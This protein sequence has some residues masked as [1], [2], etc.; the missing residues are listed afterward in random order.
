MYV[1]GIDPP[2][3]LR[4]DEGMSLLATECTMPAGL[5]LEV[6]LARA[7]ERAEED[8]VTGLLEGVEPGELLIQNLSVVVA[9]KEV[10]ESITA[11][12]ASG[13]TKD[14][15]APTASHGER[16]ARLRREVGDQMWEPRF[17]IL[18]RQPMWLV[19]QVQVPKT[20]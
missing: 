17:Q 2:L 10:L 16:D 14:V 5:V 12:N 6:D 3:A 9:G 11:M 13:G 8:Q 19:R 15:L 7:L 4:E 1:G 20:A 18:V